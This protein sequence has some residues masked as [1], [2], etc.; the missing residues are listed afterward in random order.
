MKTSI[1]FPRFQ[2]AHQEKPSCPSFRDLQSPSVDRP[3]SFKSTCQLYHPISPSENKTQGEKKKTILKRWGEKN[4]SDI[5]ESL[6]S[7]CSGLWGLAQPGT[8]QSLSQVCLSSSRQWKQRSSQQYIFF[9]NHFGN[10]HV[11]LQQ[12]KQDTHYS[13]T[14]MTSPSCC[15]VLQGPAAKTS[16]SL[17]AV[18]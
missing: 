5:F 6:K 17:Y 9:Q 7:L 16:V 18:Q 12:G 3:G 1:A 4:L 11:S 10:L 13:W 14:F 2:Q 8:P 15:G